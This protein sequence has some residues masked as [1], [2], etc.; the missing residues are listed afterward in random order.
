MAHIAGDI[1][2]ITFNHPTLGNGVFYPKTGEGATIDKGGIRTADDAA[3]R[4]ANGQAIYVK[5]QVNWMLEVACKCDIKNTPNDLEVYTALC[6]SNEEAD[7][8]TTH[9]SGAVY[10]GKGMPVGDAQT[11]AQAGT[12]TLKISGGG[13]LEKIA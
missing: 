11:D 12:F 6:E 3:N 10:G 13:K 2:E 7:W 9:I 1:T 8:T 5:N 4:A